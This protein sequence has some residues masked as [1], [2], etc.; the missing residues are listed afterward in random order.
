MS[1]LDQI[2]QCRVQHGQ[3]CQKRSQVRNSALHG[4][5]KEFVKCTLSTLLPQFFQPTDRSDLKWVHEKASI[6]P[7]TKYRSAFNWRSVL[8]AHHLFLQ[9]QS[10]LWAFLMLLGT[11]LQIGELW[12]TLLQRQSS[13]LISVSTQ[14][15]GNLW[16]LPTHPHEQLS[17]RQ[18]IVVVGEDVWELLKHLHAVSVEE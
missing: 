2:G 16:N 13:T 4:A 12:R 5:L 18:V 9:L 11:V 8:R 7:K 1:H 10:L 17:A 15:I 6:Q 14:M 3:I